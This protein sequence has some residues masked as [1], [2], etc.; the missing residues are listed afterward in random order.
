TVTN[1]GRPDTRRRG[2]PSPGMVKLPVTGHPGIDSRLPR[3][4][5]LSPV[6]PENLGF[7]IQAFWRKRT[8]AKY[9]RSKKEKQ[10]S[11]RLVRRSGRQRLLW[12]KLVAV[13]AA[14]RSQE[15]II[16]I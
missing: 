9:S 14:H 5:S 12:R 1:C 2:V 8:G 15:I 10:I 3:S 11:G 4:G 16:A 7:A 6:T 13:L